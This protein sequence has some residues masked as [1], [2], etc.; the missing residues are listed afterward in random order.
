MSSVKRAT[1]L[2][3]TLIG[4]VSLFKGLSTFVGYLMWKQPLLKNSNGTI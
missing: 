3:T 4:L 1:K 2:L